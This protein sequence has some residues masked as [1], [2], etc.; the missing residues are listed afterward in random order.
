MLGGVVE[1]LRDVVGGGVFALDAD[2]LR[3]VEVF[4][5]EFLY[6]LRHR[7]REE[8]VQA[9]VCWRHLPQEVAHII[10]ETK[11]KHAVCFVQHADFDVFQ[12]DDF[13]FVEVDDAPRRADDNVY[14]RVFEQ[15][16]LV[17]HADA[18]V[19]GKAVQPGVGADLVGVFFDLYGQFARGR[20]DDGPRPFGFG[21]DGVGEQVMVEGDEK[22]SG[23]AG[24]GLRQSHHV[25]PAQGQRQGFFLYRRGVGEAVVFQRFLDCRMDGQAA[26]SGRGGMVFCHVVSLLFKVLGA[27]IIPFFHFPGSCA[28]ATRGGSALLYCA[29]VIFCAFPVRFCFMKRLLFFILLPLVLQA[30]ALLRSEQSLYEVKMMAGD[31]L[32]ARSEPKKDD[33]GFYRFSDV[34]GR[35]YKVKS[36][37]VLYIKPAKFKR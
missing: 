18:A 7:R 34:N 6:F 37:L 10:N 16:A 36:N 28:H 32:Y 31:V 14:R 23:F 25:V 4:V 35:D 17:F 3:R 2:G 27:R 24:P 13:L 11:V 19:D 29:A 26:E 33:K 20:K 15:V 30:C 21:V 12:A 1:D 5:G 8:Q 9:F 22:G